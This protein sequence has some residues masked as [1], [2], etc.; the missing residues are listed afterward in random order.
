MA[1]ET[2]RNPKK[3]SIS[4]I[5]IKPLEVSLYQTY[6]EVGVLA[7]RQHYLHLWEDQN[8]DPYINIAFTLEVL[9]NEALNCNTK[10]FL[11][12]KDT[13]AIGILK[14]NLEHSLGPHP[15]TEVLL[16]DKIYIMKA[17]SGQGVGKKVLD[18]VEK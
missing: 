4:N 13:L 6:I 14:I 9:R 2:P 1:I 8:P 3:G 5:S 18:F 17:Y 15:S 12:Y 11:V 7:Y 10:L 16:F